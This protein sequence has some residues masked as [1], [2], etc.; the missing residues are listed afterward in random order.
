MTANPSPTMAFVCS[1][2]SVTPTAVNNAA[3][4]RHVEASDNRANK[5][6]FIMFFL[7]ENL[8]TINFQCIDSE[9]IL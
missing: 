5:Y 1:G 3:R 2:D 8:L 7:V 9:P 6:G 4:P